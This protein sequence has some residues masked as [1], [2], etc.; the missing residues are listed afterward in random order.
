MAITSRQ[1]EVSDELGGSPERNGRR[2]SD[3][4][5]Q[6]DAR[7][8]ARFILQSRSKLLVG[9]RVVPV[10]AMLFGIATMAPSASATACHQP[11][12]IAVNGGRVSNQTTLDL[13]ADGGFAISNANGGDN[14]I[15]VGGSG[16]LIG[17]GGD[18][19][20][21]NA[22][23]AV[24]E[25]NGGMIDL[26][27]INSGNNAGN[28]IAI[29]AGSAPC[30]YG[31]SNVAIDGGTVSNET[32]LTLSA[33][34]GF[35]VANANGGDNNIAVAGAG[36]LLGNGG[37][38]SA[39]L[40]G[41][42]VAQANGG[43]ITV[44][45]VNS[46]NNRGNTILV[47]GLFGRASNVRI[48]GGI[49]RNTTTIAISADGGT[50]VSNANGGDGNIAVGGSGGV[51]GNG[52]DAAAGNGGVAVAEANG[53][54]VTVGDI[55]SGGNSGNTIVVEGVQG[56]NVAVDGGTVTN[57]TTIDISAD[58]GTAVSNADGG[59]GNIAVAGNGGIIGDGGDASAGNGGVAVSEA[60]GGN[61]SIGDVNSGGNSGNTI[62]VGS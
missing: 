13:S 41:V 17:N 40:G 31:P 19:A 6:T 3:M 30:G 50:A 55:N 33:D 15:A 10:A 46:G 8:A 28:T 20:A 26:D 4:T 12:N 57:E 2:E 51:I 37:N 14:N 27:D 59:D 58:G 48:D 18:A 56:G 36:G 16:G 7:G 32:T 60:N 44:G 22:G 35:A 42:A 38:A 24:A 29:S 39:G 52:G 61:I 62:V 11:A 49:V 23:V 5:N 47:G 21:G 9:L 25:A 1:A 54:T 34:G 43:A 45:D 53:G